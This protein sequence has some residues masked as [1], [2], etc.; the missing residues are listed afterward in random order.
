MG[1]WGRWGRR[2]KRRGEWEEWGGELGDSCVEF[3]TN[4]NYFTAAVY[5]KLTVG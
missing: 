3:V 1:R 2:K 4:R 5:V